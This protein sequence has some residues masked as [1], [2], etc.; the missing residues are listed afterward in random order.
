MN[1]KI[2][3]MSALA[4]S[5]ATGAAMAQQRQRNIGLGRSA[6]DVALLYRCGDEDDEIRR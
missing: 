2:L 3:C 6:E 5:L 1:T 4:F